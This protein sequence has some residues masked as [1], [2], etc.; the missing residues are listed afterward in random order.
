[1]DR[2]YQDIITEHLENEDQMIFLAGPRQVGKTTLAKEAELLTSYFKYFNWDNAEHRKELLSDANAIF[3]AIELEKVT[4]KMP[5]IVIDEIH[6]YKK[7]KSFIKGL[8]DTYRERARIIVT[9]S[10]KLNIYRK[11]GDSLM[12]RYFLYRVHPL[13]LGEIIHQK[14]PEDYFLRKPSLMQQAEIDTLLDFGGFPSPFL[15]RDLR[16]YNRWQ[17]L[18][19]E[20]F[21][22]EDVRELSEIHDIALME[23]LYQFLQEQVGQL[24]SYTELSKKLGVSAPTIKSWINIFEELYY[25]F[26]IKPWAKNITRSLIKMPKLYLYD[27]SQIKDKGQKIE[28]FVASHLLKAV[29]FW[30]DV[31]LGNFQLFFLRDKNK[32]EVDFLVTKDDKPW[33][34]I[35]AKSNG[36]KGLSAALKNYQQ[37]LNVPY[38]IQLAYDMPYE[39]I[40]FRDLKRPTILPMSSF[41]SQL[42]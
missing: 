24:L 29:H 27:W 20:Q 2:I 19:R 30:K 14:A 35:E 34:L 36:N 4:K 10:A 5:V 38:A 8:Y 25:C 18:R 33:I 26:R 3:E 32:N 7:W 28:N 15:R 16:Q 11:S 41:L 39:D 40:D 37:Q 23:V 17:M 13:S 22:K 1:M 12:G 9:G 6:K 21:F 42:P 31:G